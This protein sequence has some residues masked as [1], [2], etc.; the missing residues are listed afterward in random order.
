MKLNPNRAELLLCGA[1]LVDPA[2]HDPKGDS[3]AISGGRILATGWKEQLTTLCSPETRYIDCTGLTLLPG[4]IDGHAHLDREGLK[5]VLPSIS[6]AHS[7]VEIQR[8]LGEVVMATPPGEWIVLSPLGTP[9]LFKD[10]WSKL[11]EGRCPNRHDLDMVAPDNPV[12]IRPIWGYWSNQPDLVSVANT[13]ALELAG[14]G[15]TTEPPHPLV[16][17]HRDATGLPDGRFHERTRVSIVEMTLMS[18]AP[19]FD[20]TTRS[21]AMDV[22][23]QTYARYGTTGIYEGHGVAEEVI[24]AYGNLQQRGTGCL[25]A[26][27]VVSPKWSTAGDDT[28]MKE[29]IL[30]WTA[31]AKRGLDE[32]DLLRVEGIYAEI[33]ETDEGI[34]RASAAPCTGWAGFHLDCGGKPALVRELLLEAARQGLRV[35]TI[36]D[37]VMALMGEVDRIHPLAGL[38]WVRGHVAT[39]DD[40]A[41]GAIGDMGL[42]LV[43]HTN[44]H[45]A[46]AGSAH[47]ARLGRGRAQEIV[48]IRR[49][50]DAGIPI[51]LGSDN[52]PPSLLHP[53]ADLELRRDHSTGETIAP[54]QAITRREALALATTG[55]AALLGHAA[56]LGHLKAGYLADLAGFPTDILS[57]PAEELRH[58]EA[59]LTLVGGKVL[60]QPNAKRDDGS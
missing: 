2:S 8:I 30:D 26:T 38:G 18:A 50:L 44:R 34:L 42:T 43:T 36:F 52:L 28:D 5:S 19:G 48:P 46:K 13:A 16:T 54:D 55:G 59:K 3:I 39:L 14:I 1:H 49:L 17:I 45:I 33:D 51:A 57:I 58:L 6:G 29:M 23:M 41:I 32:S 35:S 20:V 10:G 31:W 37:D 47:L 60:R 25:R 9:P 7:I 11:A 24:E 27:L 12:W 4:L 21:K 15:R 56:D 53:I 40:A 22:S